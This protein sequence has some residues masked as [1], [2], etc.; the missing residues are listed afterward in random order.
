MKNT[1]KDRKFQTFTIML[2]PEEQNVLRRLRCEY[3]INIS[4]TVKVILRKK[5]EQL[6]RTNPDLDIINT[7]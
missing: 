3:A 6:D 2:N 7:L 5:L 4:G 1:K